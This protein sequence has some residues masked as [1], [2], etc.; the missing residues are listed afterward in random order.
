MKLGKVKLRKIVGGWGSSPTLQIWLV[1]RELWYSHLK[2]DQDPILRG[3]KLTMLIGHDK[4]W[5][6][7]SK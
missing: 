5:D 2:P 1:F 7:F 6:D 4:S 3:R